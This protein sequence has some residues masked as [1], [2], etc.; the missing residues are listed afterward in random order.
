[1][2]RTS[3]VNSLDFSMSYAGPLPSVLQVSKHDY[4]YRIY[5]KCSKI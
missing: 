3:S 1:M 4:M 2:E 5:S